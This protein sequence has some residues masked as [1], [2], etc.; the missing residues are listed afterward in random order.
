MKPQLELQS[1]TATPLNPPLL[2]FVVQPLTHNKYKVG[3][4]T[5]GAHS[6]SHLRWQ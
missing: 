6:N 5:K 2:H 3:S 4:T 1:G